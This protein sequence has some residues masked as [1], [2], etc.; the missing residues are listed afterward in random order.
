MLNEK[1]KV[2]ALDQNQNHRMIP[3]RDL[4]HSL[5]KTFFVKM[6]QD[7]NQ[8][9]VQNPEL[10]LKL[11]IN[12][13]NVEVGLAPSLI[14]HQNR[15]EHRHRFE[16]TT[17]HVRVRAGPAVGVETAK[18]QEHVVDVEVKVE[19]VVDLENEESQNQES[20]VVLEVEGIEAEL[21]VETENA[22]R[23]AQGRETE[24]RQSHAITRYQESH[25]LFLKNGSI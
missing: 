14:F 25:F 12:R 11:E 5:K 18:E 7:L 17:S 22:L 15:P 23:V 21:E 19:P 13:A 8:S 20:E 3:D 24:K 2:R 16:I 1:H 9:R 6:L 10:D 4:D